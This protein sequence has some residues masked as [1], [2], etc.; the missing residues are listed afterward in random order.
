V[1]DR[2]GHCLLV[3]LTFIITIITLEQAVQK[4]KDSSHW[5]RVT[6]MVECNCCWV[7]W[8]RGKESICTL[9][10]IWQSIQHV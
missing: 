5:S 3:L 10:W 4:C 7:W 6:H 1:E 9:E 2:H 8:I